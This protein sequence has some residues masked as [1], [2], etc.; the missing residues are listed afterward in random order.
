M[1]PLSNVDVPNL[2]GTA[3]FIISGQF[4][5]IAPP[6][7]AERLAHVLTSAGAEVTLRLQPAGHDLT[8]S[9]VENARDWLAC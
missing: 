1:I 4:D 3:V 2:E 5:P 6:I 9:D 8:H 7:I